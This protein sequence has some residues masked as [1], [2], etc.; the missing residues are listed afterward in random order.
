MSRHQS[1]PQNEAIRI[2]FAYH[3]GPIT[4]AIGR[5]TMR[6]NAGCTARYSATGPDLALELDGSPACARSAPPYVPG[7]P[8]GV[9]HALIQAD[10]GRGLRQG[11]DWVGS[12]LVTASLPELTA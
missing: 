3:E 10:R 1:G 6:D 5:D 7:Q 8:V 4:L 12:L 11:V 2:F 9:G